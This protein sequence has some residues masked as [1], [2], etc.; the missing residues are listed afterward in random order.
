MRALASCGEARFPGLTMKAI[1]ISVGPRAV[2]DPRTKDHRTDQALST[3]D[4]GHVYC[5]LFMVMSNT[6]VAFG[7]MIDPG[8]L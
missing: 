7:G 4:Q 8:G 6:S 3:K 5:T 1:D 2:A